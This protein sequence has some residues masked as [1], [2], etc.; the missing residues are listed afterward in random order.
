MRSF[1]RFFLATAMIAAVLA[2]APAAALLCV[3][4][5]VAVM[6]PEEAVT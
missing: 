2:P 1:L 3:M 5:P 6:P 4:T